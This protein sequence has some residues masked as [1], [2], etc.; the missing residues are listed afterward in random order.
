MALELYAQG[1]I[2]QAYAGQQHSYQNNA[3]RTGAEETMFPGIGVECTLLR[4]KI[5]E[6][7]KKELWMPYVSH[8]K[9]K[10]TDDATRV[11]VHA[12][13]PNVYLVETDFMAPSLS[14]SLLISRAD[15]LEHWVHS[16][17]KSSMVK[18]L[19][20]NAYIVKISVHNPIST[21]LGCCEKY[22]KVSYAIDDTARTRDGAKKRQKAFVTYSQVSHA[23][24]RV[25]DIPKI[26]ASRLTPD[27]FDFES[28]LFVIYDSD[29]D[30][31]VQDDCS[32]SGRARVR[33]SMEEITTCH[34]YVEGMRFTKSSPAF[35]N[36]MY[37]PDFFNR[38][39]LN[40]A[41]Q[42]RALDLEHSKFGRDL[43]GIRKML[44]DEQIPYP[45]VANLMLPK[46]ADKQVDPH[47]DDLLDLQ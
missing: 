23:D 8:S 38:M 45:V 5:L 14:V 1:K 13:Q 30:S 32:S 9:K 15:F 28:V 44:V 17:P 39:C 12:S 7:S 3:Q 37:L 26:V 34:V 36:S 42:A 47:V 29:N 33:D 16:I 2:F 19:E 4:R 41:I 31:L 46:P 21:V 18:R 27:F 24:C 20:H 6:I 10:G 22:I 11:H 43:L 35:F 40:W 25:Y